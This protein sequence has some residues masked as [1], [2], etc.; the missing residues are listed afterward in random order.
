M[1]RI[2]PVMFLVGDGAGAVLRWWR[3]GESVSDSALDCL[4][5]DFTGVFGSD[6]AMGK[7]YVRE[8]SCGQYLEHI[9]LAFGSYLRDP[10]WQKGWIDPNSTEYTGDC[11]AACA[12]AHCDSQT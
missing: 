12:R 1:V 10:Y 3:K 8:R 9:L 7:R 2:L 5:F 11:S 4:K 6:T